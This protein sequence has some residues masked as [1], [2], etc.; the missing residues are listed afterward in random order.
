[1]NESLQQVAEQR[2]QQTLSP[3]QVQYARALEMTG[4]E[5][6]DEVRRALDDNP[7]LEEDDSTAIHTET[8]NDSGEDGFNETADE[9][10]RADYGDEDEIPHYRLTSDNSSADDPVY[11]P[12]SSQPDEETLL[13]NIRRQLELLPIDE[14]QRALALYIAGNIDQ[15]GYLT[16]TVGQMV[17]DLAFGSGIDI[18]RSKM[19]D[20][21]RIVQ[22]LDP[23]GIGAADLRQSLQLQLQ[24]IPSDAH[25]N[26]ALTIVSDYFDLFANKH[27]DRLKSTSGFD[28]GR[29]REALD[30]IK[31]LNPKPGA[32]FDG[33]SADEKLRR[34]VPD[35][36]VEQEGR[37]LTVSMT[38][39][40]PQLRI[41]SSFD[42]DDTR[43]AQRQQTGNRAAE[44]MTFVRRKRDEANDFIKAA[45]MRRDTLMRVMEAIVKLQRDFFLTGDTLKL[46]PMILKDVSEMTGYDLSVVSRATAGKYVQAPTGVYPLKFFFN[47]RPKDDL[48]ASAHELLEA[49]RQEIESEDHSNPLSD[50]ELSD[51]LTSKGYDIARRTVTKYRERLGL[52]VARLRREL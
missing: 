21:L 12:A 29:L 23:A 41:A 16:R 15:N 2:L 6:E 18:E 9:M 25:R 51:R 3:L 42:I 19:Q 20:A 50:Q 40:I 27:Y 28:S 17:D 39:N 11:D 4:P 32:A 10:M 38:G 33:S 44:A 24:R 45:T 26:D 46:K 7:A 5:F 34:I 31:T 8:E 14:Q 13:D 43:I 1:M 47:E 36:E 52:P 37:R 49:L 35:F 48:D 22:S 30:L